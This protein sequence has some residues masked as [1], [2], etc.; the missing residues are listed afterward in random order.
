MADTL[1]T[2]RLDEEDD[3]PQAAPAKDPLTESRD[4]ARKWLTELSAAKK[5]MDKFTKAA[6]RCE[7][8]YFDEGSDGIT[9]GDDDE[10]MGKVNL[11]W[12][13]VQVTCA[14]I[15]GR[16]PKAD[17]KRKFD[18]FDDDVSR[19]AGTIM[20]RILNADLEREWDDTNAV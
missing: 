5:W 11:F 10:G 4:E 12:S 8:A 18:D 3:A 13:N 14:A 1:A 2:D 6:E 19:V 16:L 20:Q 7:R 17:V 15:Y 9:F